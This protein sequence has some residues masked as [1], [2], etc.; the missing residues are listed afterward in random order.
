[1]NTQHGGTMTRLFRNRYRVDTVRMKNWDY[2]ANGYYFITI[3]VDHHNHHYFGEIVN[4]KLKV[5]SLGIIAEKHWCDI[6]D[7][8]E[9]VELHESVI[10]PNHIHGIIR[11]N[12]PNSA[13]I[14]PIDKERGGI[15]HEKNPILRN[16][17]VSEV[18]RAFKA[19]VT[20]DIHKSLPGAQFKWESRFYDRIIRDERAYH[21]ISHY[22]RNNPKKWTDDTSHPKN[23]SF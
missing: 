8:H 11:V 3:C 14:N 17:S 19:R 18:I 4:A 5:S 12:L 7:H 9:G 13:V 15:T 21:N 10:M 16:H 20:R 23:Q 1:M 22:I 2:G 6:P